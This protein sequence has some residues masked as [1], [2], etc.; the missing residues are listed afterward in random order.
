MQVDH[1]ALALAVTVRHDGNGGVADDL[2]E[3]AG[4][5]AWVRGQGPALEEFGFSV[6]GEDGR[7]GPDRQV[8][9]RADRAALDAAVE[10]R[11]ALRALFARAVLPGAPSKAD[12]GRLPDAGA[13]LERLN[14]AAARVPVTPRL[15][16][17][18][19]ARPVADCAAT[20]RHP[21][22]D[23]LAAALARAGIAF[24]AG[25]DSAR[26]RACPAPRCVRYFVQAH[27]RQEWC[28]P[29]CGNRARVA[30]HHARHRTPSAEGS[31]PPAATAG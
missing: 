8:L 10:V 31:N 2:A 13:A 18:A 30:R 1:L 26:L 16:W 24:L 9:F 27:A 15:A 17:P 22:A 25:P 3:P 19:D 23:L 6:A 20:G 11:T 14:A 28:K 29:S 12:A 21:A 4:L 7:G 5:T